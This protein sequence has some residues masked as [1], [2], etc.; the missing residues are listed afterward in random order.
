[1]VWK[2]EVFAYFTILSIVTDIVE[3]GLEPIHEAILCLSDILYAGDI[4][5]GHIFP[6]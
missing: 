5:F 6:A 4:V 2:V 3:V 1:M